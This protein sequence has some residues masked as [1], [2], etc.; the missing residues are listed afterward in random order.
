VDDI[1]SEERDL[2][3]TE[4]LRQI[5]SVRLVFELGFPADLVAKAKSVVDSAGIFVVRNEKIRY[6]ASFV[7][8]IVSLA[9]DRRG[10]SFWT[11]DEVSPL[12]RQMH[13][14]P[15][16]LAE[17]TLDAIKTLRL[18][19]F[20]ELIEEENALKY[21]TPV[22]MHSGIPVNNVADLVYLIDVAV[23]RLRYT[24]E[25]QIQYWSSTPHGFAGLW[26]APRRLLRG[27][28]IIA[29]DLLEQFNEALRNPNAPEVSGLPNHLVEAI[30]SIEKGSRREVGV[31]SHRLISVPQTFIEIDVLS[32]L[33]PVVRLPL[34]D[35]QEIKRWRL[36]GANDADVKAEANEE[37]LVRL[38]PSKDYEVS[39][40]G[41]DGTVAKSRFFRTYRDLPVMFFNATSGQLLERQSIGIQCDGNE[42]IALTHPKV[43]F[44]G[45]DENDQN[46]TVCTGSWD[47]WKIR[48]L[49]LAASRQL[50]A[51]DTVHSEVKEIISFIQPTVR[52]SLVHK[53]QCELPMSC[54]V[55][56][57]FVEVPTL[58]IDTGGADTSIVNVYVKRGDEYG[59]SRKLSELDVSENQYDL[60]ELFDNDG[61]YQVS[62]VGPLGLRMA[63]K[64]IVL[65]RGLECIQDPPLGLP[66]QPVTIEMNLPNESTEVLISADKFDGLVVIKGVAI[67]VRPIRV[68][69]AISV[70][71][72]TPSRMSSDLFSFTSNEVG[73][74]SE[75]NLFVRTGMPCTIEIEMSDGMSLIHST[76]YEMTDRR[77]INLSEFVKHAAEFGSEAHTLSARVGNSQPFI[78]GGFTSDYIVSLN[79]TVLINSEEIEIVE[80]TFVENKRFSNRVIRIWSLD[81]PWEPS[82]SVSLPND[83]VDSFSLLLPSGSRAGK[84]RLWLKIEGPHAQVPRLPRTETIGVID[85]ILQYGAAPD[86][87]NPVDRI[88]EAVSK[89]N[90]D[91]VRETDVCEHGHVL[92]GLLA[93]NMGDK[94]S[95]GLTDRLGA[96]VY[97]LLESD[98][99][100]L[101][102]HIVTAL[103]RDIINEQLLLQITLAIMPLLFEAEDK[104]D[105]SVSSEF[106]ELV[107][108]RLPIVA[109]IASPW[110]DSIEMRARWQDKFGW[111]IYIEAE[112]KDDDPLETNETDEPARIEPPKIRDVLA[113]EFELD[114]R[115][116]SHL[117]R[118]DVEAILS[119]MIGSRASE[120]LSIDGE[121]DAVAKSILSAVNAQSEINIWRD[122]HNRTLTRCHSYASRYKY[123]QLVEQYSVRSVWM[124]EPMYKWILFDI[125]VLAISA[126]DDREK[127]DSQMHALLDAMDFAPAWVEYA[128]LLALSMKPLESE[129]NLS[130]I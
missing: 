103:D 10:R 40:I 11:S 90:I 6:P 120:F 73:D 29:I 65:L 119:T 43:A 30:N 49:Q 16:Q 26:A 98:L 59:A 2:I 122:L 72:R 99:E 31:G 61:E 97:R 118:R 60:T 34:V 89:S 41:V 77:V 82:W 121:W 68:V 107:W 84:Y 63:E 102:K 110:N 28:N 35:V 1:T 24:P 106:A 127:C 111:P 109:A 128:L 55:G 71:Y 42:V 38:L 23:R 112:T 91:A 88:V 130:R 83:V 14:E 115:R 53:R 100:N 33:G 126:V 66:N 8:Y 75:L 22:T 25:E 57:L 18:E 94:G 92:L 93:L 125:M 101:I 32:S 105:I 52:P 36:V 95:A 104:Y 17:L 54:S 50:E 80:L 86:M 74:P 13:R 62:V 4:V 51:F 123:R 114:V 116:V 96:N 108:T 15:H 87:D 129:T 47:G 78:L 19:T 67:S 9:K 7:L 45:L 58:R 76:K 44:L 64:H 81:R 113:A 79:G 20:D 5:K 37:T 85:I 124:D 69:W 3:E 12:C 27:G 56:E 21:M 117:P 46:Q 48:R 70:G 39:A